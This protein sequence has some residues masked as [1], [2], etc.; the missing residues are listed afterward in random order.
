MDN[1][2][3]R[4][5]GPPPLGGRRSFLYIKQYR[6]TPRE[7]KHH[8][9]SGFSEAAAQSARRQNQSHLVLMRGL[10]R[11]FRRGAE[12][13]R[14]QIYLLVRYVIFTIGAEIATLEPIHVRFI[15]AF[16][17]DFPELRPYLESVRTGLI[18]LPSRSPEA[19]SKL[20]VK[21]TKETILTAKIRG[22]F[23]IYRVQIQLNGKASFG[24]VS[25]FRDDY[26]NPLTIYTPIME[27]NGLRHDLLACLSS[28]KLE[29]HFFDEIKRERFAYR[30]RD[31]VKSDVE[32]VFA[33][34]EI[35][36]NMDNFLEAHHA[37]V[38]WFSARCEVDDENALEAKLG[39]PLYDDDFSIANMEDVH[40]NL[41]YSPIVSSLVRNDPGLES[42]DDI[43]QCLARSFK[44]GLVL[45]GPKKQADGLE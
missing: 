2:A 15:H 12:Y 25:A 36:P 45:V 38:A 42:E 23:H 35:Y 27:D 33:T 9:A 29:I 20:V 43:A 31:L 14:H 7:E 30:S 3:L 16:L 22:G 21:A 18:P 41:L 4:L 40:Q 8:G 11:S 32:R 37:A 44:S 5:C 28:N 6:V 39:E 24:L 13:E 26:E 34:A 10:V 19:T 1:A 17:I